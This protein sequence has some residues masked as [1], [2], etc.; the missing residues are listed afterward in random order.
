MDNRKVI[1][2]TEESISRAKLLKRDYKPDNVKV[3]GQKVFSS[4]K[5]EDE[6]YEPAIELLDSIYFQIQNKAS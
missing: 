4:I 3:I 2:E 6:F 5:E 1:F